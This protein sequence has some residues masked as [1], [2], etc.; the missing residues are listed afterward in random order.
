MV[1]SKMHRL[2][3]DVSPHEQRRRWVEKVLGLGKI[4]VGANESVLLRARMLGNSGVK[5]FDALHA[6]SAEAAGASHFITC[7]DRLIRRYIG[8]LTCVDPQNFITIASRE[9]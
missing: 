9:Q 2:E 6:S 7:D 3:N 4:K 8:P 1:V 5:P